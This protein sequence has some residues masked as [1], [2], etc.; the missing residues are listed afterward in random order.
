VSTESISEPQK[1]ILVVDDQKDLV[2]LLVRLLS[3]RG[4]SVTGALSLAEAERFLAAERFDLVVSDIEMGAE[5]GMDL[6]RSRK[7]VAGKQMERFIFLSGAD[8]LDTVAAELSAEKLCTFLA[9]PAD[10]QLL[11]SVV[12]NVCS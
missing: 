11:L 3:R 7:A 5:N 12:R 6:F 1:R 9:K 4:Y 2:D 10:F 8:H